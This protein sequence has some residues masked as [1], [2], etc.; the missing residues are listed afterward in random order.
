MI[1]VRFK[2]L[3]LNKENSM[4]EINPIGKKTHQDGFLY[5][6]NLKGSDFWD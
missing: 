6:D 3:L 5:H 1:F 4:S 2:S